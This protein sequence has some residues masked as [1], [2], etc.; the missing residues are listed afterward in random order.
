MHKYILARAFL[1]RRENYVIGNFTEPPR[2]LAATLILVAVTGLIGPL[3]L[4]RPE[5]VLLATYASVPLLVAA[6]LSVSSLT[7]TA[8]LPGID[9]NEFRLSVAVFLFLQGI[10]IYLLG[11]ASVRPLVYYVL[12]AVMSTLIFGQILTLVSAARSP[13]ILAEIGAVLLNVAWGV[14]FKYHY[15]F[16][17]TDV[18]PHAWYVERVVA[19][20]SI[21]GEM[22]VYQQHPLWHVFGA[23]ELGVLDLPL[24]PRFALFFANGLTF[25]VAVIAIYALTRAVF[26]DR[27]PLN[28]VERLALTAALLTALNSF[29][30]LYA[31]YSIPRSVTSVLGL[32]V[33]FAVLRKGYRYS[34]LFVF[35]T[36]GIAAYHTVSIPF[37]LVVLVTL[38][39]IQFVLGTHRVI[40]LSELAAMAGIQ[41]VYW[42]GIAR[43]TFGRIKRNLFLRGDL[44]GEAGPSLD[45]VSELVNYLSFSAL[46]LLTAYG[47]LVTLADRDVSPAGRLLVLG[48]L[49]LAAIS[50]PGP[51][52]LIGAV[53]SFNLLRMG[54]YTYP[55]LAIAGAVGLLALARGSL[56]TRS[57]SNRLFLGLAVLLVL[58]TGFFAVSNDFVASDNPLVE[59]ESFY[60]FYLTEAETTGF[61]TLASLTPGFLHSDQVT[62]KRISNGPYPDTCHILEAN[63]DSSTLLQDSHRDVFLVR[64]TELDERAL[65]V[66]PTPSFERRPSYLGSL[67]SV[68]PE[69][70]LWGEL[71][72]YN[73][74]YVSEDVA[75]YTN[76]TDENRS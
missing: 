29:V 8:G 15:F 52:Q 54:Q 74:V 66:Y 33:I 4:G 35:L 76:H 51:L 17:R 62:C 57:T 61:D 14:T 47:A 65:T 67:Q 7:Q 48:G 37:I 73:R 32:L 46:I 59:R 10:S 18:F 55:L 39:L 38:Y 68:G 31:M 42:V 53:E 22:G 20:G 1:S 19:T 11:V 9:A 25:L 58:T 50:F 40:R 64:T 72:T 24:E 27:L 3:L 5:L 41:L 63:L 12:V 75:A 2:A 56:P 60:T 70:P 26:S 30:I 36:I 71:R 21:P 13:V 23:I 16:G 34:G 45:P 69:A 44:A 43:T 6:L 49:L 28:E